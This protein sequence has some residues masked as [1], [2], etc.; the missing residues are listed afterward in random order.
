MG[1]RSSGEDVALRNILFVCKHNIFRSKI[2][3]AYFKK[4]N[5]DRKITIRSAGIIRGDVL[6]KDQ[7]EAV[8]LEKTIAKKF[9]IKIK[10]GFAGLSISLLKKQDLIIV[11]ADDVSKI[12]FNNKTYVKKVIHWKIKDYGF[13]GRG[14]TTNIIKQIMK[15]VDNLSKKLK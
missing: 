9:G 6:N 11:A 8:G 4:I 10:A 14:H 7:R 15:K 1:I 13:Y 5:K 3:E 2:A 12:I